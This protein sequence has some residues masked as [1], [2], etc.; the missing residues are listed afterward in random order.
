M[1]SLRDMSVRIKL[2]GGFGAVL[3]LAAVLGVTSIS[4]VGSVNQK[5][6]RIYTSN[7][8]A[9]DQ[10]GAA[11]TA[12]T[13]EQRLL[14][15]GISFAQDQSIQREVDQNVPADQAL[16]EQ[17]MKAFSG[18]GMTS[19]ESAGVRTIQAAVTSICRCETAFARS[20][21]RAT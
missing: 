19:T 11:N 10:M 21:K 12:V 7:V 1:K 13:D 5:G 8:M 9:V 20:R 6:A 14:Y 3:L 17:Q 16:F 15:Q 2:F 18:A 4:S